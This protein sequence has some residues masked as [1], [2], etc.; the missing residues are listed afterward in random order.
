MCDPLTAGVVLMGVTTA[1]S[2]NQGYQQGKYEE[3][4]GKYNARVSQNQAQEVR[5]QGNEAENAHRQRVAELLS[6]QRAQLGAS[7]VS[8]TSG[9]PLQLQQDTITLGEA[10]ALRIRNNY[11]SKVGALGVESTLLESQGKFA[12]S[13][14][15]SAAFGSLLKGG[16]NIMGTGVADK[17]FT[18]NSS[19]NV[20]TTL[21]GD[22]ATMKYGNYA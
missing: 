1:V 7:G 20:T 18:P 17:W 15:N 11:S 12:K 9:S 10:D 8:L 5:N 6:K 21:N 4:V 16:S 2:V 13:A 22:T 3:G 14:G 19:A